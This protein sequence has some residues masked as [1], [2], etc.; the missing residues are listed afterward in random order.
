LVLDLLLAACSMY[1]KLH[2]TPCSEQWQVYATNIGYDTYSADNGDTYGVKTNVQDFLAYAA[3]MTYKKLLVPNKN[4]DS[5]F[6]LRD[7]WM[8]LFP[9]KCAIAKQRAERGAQVGPGSGITLAV[10]CVNVHKVEDA[11]Y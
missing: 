4:G 2:T 6:I 7:E 8:K 10:W 1:D 9:E 5:P 3:Y 11:E